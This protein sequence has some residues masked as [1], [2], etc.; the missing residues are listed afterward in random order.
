MP[1]QVALIICT[2]FVLWLL[3][4]DHLQAPEVSFALWI[5][6]IWMLLIATKPLGLWFGVGAEDMESGNPLDRAVLSGI[7]CLG[8]L[9]LAKRRFIWSNAIKENIFLILLLGYML[10]SIF[11]SNMP[12]VSFKRWVREF[13]AIVMVFMVATELDPKKALESIFRRTI[14]VLIPFSYMLIHYFPLYGRDYGRWSGVQ[15]WVGVAS[16]KNGLGRLCLFAAFFLIWVFIT[17]RQKKNAP[18]IKYQNYVEAFILLLTFWLMGGPQ[19]NFSYSVTTNIALAVGLMALIGL[20]WMKKRNAE[21]GTKAL[22]VIIALI[23]GYGTVTPMIGKLSLID[24]S[25]TFGR[26]ETLTGRS[27]IWAILV[28][29]AMQKPILGYGFGGFWTD[30]M[31]QLTSS[32]AHNGYLDVVLNLGFVGLLLFVIFL[33]VCSRKAQKIMIKDFDWGALLI[34][35]LLIIVVHNI[36]ETSFTSFTSQLLAVILFLSVSL[37]PTISNGFRVSKK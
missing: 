33:L 34:C 14:Y 4:L 26:D 11:W 28:P 18:V 31:R 25:T 30:A 22:I 16:Q 37:M 9:I 23:I 7:F 6:T 12:F 20:F 10:I 1:P 32:H 29:Y 24:I 5:P 15:T 27:D 3:Y 35:F 36:A 2:I 13:I 19:H 17:R 8:L 21:L